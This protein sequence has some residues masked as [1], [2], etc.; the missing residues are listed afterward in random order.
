MLHYPRLT[1]HPSTPEWTLSHALDILGI[2][3]PF[4][5]Q[6]LQSNDPSEIRHLFTLWKPLQKTPTPGQPKNDI[7]DCTIGRP[8]DRMPKAAAPQLS[9]NVAPVPFVP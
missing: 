7:I 5:D 4:R 3:R 8:C 1:P 2:E 6:I 9:W